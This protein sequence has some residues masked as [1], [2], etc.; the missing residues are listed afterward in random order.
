MKSGNYQHGRKLKS[1]TLQQAPSLTLAMPPSATA[2]SQVAGPSISSHCRTDPKAQRCSITSVNQVL[3]DSTSP[4]KSLGSIVYKI[5]PYCKRPDDRFPR[6]FWS[7]EKQDSFWPTNLTYCH[8][9][10]SPY[11]ERA[12]TATKLAGMIYPFIR[13][14]LPQISIK[15]REKES[16]VEVKSAQGKEAW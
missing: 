8:V 9:T 10:L 11:S 12:S 16:S 4:C 6:I 15:S 14:F 3:E 5:C 1:L 7:L 2:R 13:P